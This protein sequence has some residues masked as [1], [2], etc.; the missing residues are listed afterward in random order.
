MLAAPSSAALAGI[1]AYRALAFVLPANAAIALGLG[2]VLD[3][4]RD[5]RLVLATRGLVFAGLTV[6]GFT[7]LAN[8]LTDGPMYSTDYLL[9]GMQWGAPQ[10]IRDTVPRLLRVYPHA[11]VWS[12]TDWAN[13]VNVYPP[14][15]GVPE[16]RM[17]FENLDVICSGAWDGAPDDLLIIPD[18]DLAPINDCQLFAP[19]DVIGR[20]PRPDGRVGFYI[21]HLRWAPD[22]A[23]KLAAMHAAQSAPVTEQVTINGQP[24]T[25]THP[26]FE[27]GSVAELFDGLPYTTPR[28][29]RGVPM[30][31]DLRFPAPRALASVT[32]H[33]RERTIFTQDVETFA[34]DLEVKWQKD[35]GTGEMVDPVIRVDC[36]GQLVDR[37]RIEVAQ[38]PE[39]WVH[40]RDITLE[41]APKP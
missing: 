26:P 8:C 40:L 36:G 12:T 17:R 10:L 9:Y 7:L 35:H 6:S 37:V 19:F 14:F 20:V 24:V 5:P 38:G 25:V 31:I 11:G 1:A 28:C 15:F 27:L 33:H 29:Y 21:G 30:L 22:A 13:G 16:S 41:D 34:G 23:A 4:V 2:F 32:V 39:D 3:R 18:I